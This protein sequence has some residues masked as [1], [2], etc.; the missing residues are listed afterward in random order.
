MNQCANDCKD[1]KKKV[2]QSKSLGRTMLVNKKLHKRCSSADWKLDVAF[3]YTAKETPQ[4]NSL[5]ETVLTTIAARSRAALNIANVP[6]KE[7]Y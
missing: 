6:M 1:R 5:A 2:E 4:K 7:R 3:E